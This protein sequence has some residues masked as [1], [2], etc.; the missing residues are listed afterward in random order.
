M[1]PHDRLG[2]LEDVLFGLKHLLE[3]LLHPLQIVVVTTADQQI[4]PA[5]GLG[6]EIGDRIAG[7]HGIGNDDL[8]VVAGSHHGVEDLDF[9]DNSRRTSRLGVIAHADGFEEDDHHAGGEI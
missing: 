7:D 8:L 3:E 1:D 2:I 9:L 6:R 4:D 5:G